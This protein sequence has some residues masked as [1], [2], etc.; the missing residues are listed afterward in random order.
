V[1]AVENALLDIVGKHL[2]VPVCALWGGPLRTELP[3]YWSH[4]GS[5]RLQYAHHMGLPR[6]DIKPIQTLADVEEVGREVLA[7][8]HTALKT[9]IFLLDNP[10]GPCMY[11]PGFGGGLP[12]LNLP[13]GLVENLIAQLEALRRGA[14]P[15]V[16]IKLD[17]NFNFKPEGVIQIGRAL[18]DAKER[19]GPIAWLEYDI[20]DPAAMRMIKDEV[21]IPIASLESCYGRNQ[22]RPYFEARA[23]DYCIIDVLWNGAWESMKIA[24]LA[25]S[26]YI[27]C[28]THNYHGWLGTAISA[29]FCAAIPNFKVLEIDVDD[30]AWKNEI[31][32]CVPE[33]KNGM[34]TLPMGPGWGVDLDEIAIVKFPATRSP[35][36]GIWSGVAGGATQVSDE[37][38]LP[39]A[40]AD[41]QEWEIQTGEGWKLAPFKLPKH[42]VAA[43][44]RCVVRVEG[45]DARVVFTSESNGILSH[46]GEERPARVKA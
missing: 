42:G 43:G 11:M 14:G 6:S 25:E 35:T 13:F 33:V 39:A 44:K 30:V 45:C 38:P 16:G 34:L 40:G 7:S 28:A 32:T 21:K 3:V 20:L 15:T 5:F 41:A 36:S 27:N 24:A 12:E 18:V 19:I 22:F 29:H 10:D 31:V 17:L 26:Y 4:A 46:K 1:A 23:V 2:N 9:N 37:L 8:G